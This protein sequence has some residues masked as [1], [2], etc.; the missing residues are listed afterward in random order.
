MV[1]SLREDL[2]VELM[3]GLVLKRWLAS[4]GQAE[5]AGH[6]GIGHDRSEG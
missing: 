2:H 5:K 1:M 6:G 3:E 4:D